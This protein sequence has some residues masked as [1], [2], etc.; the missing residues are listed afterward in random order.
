MLCGLHGQDCDCLAAMQPS[1]AIF[2]VRMPATL[3]Q[4]CTIIVR[5][6]SLGLLWDAVAEP[7]DV[8]LSWQ[9]VSPSEALAAEYT[10]EP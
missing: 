7:Q 6:R 4:L 3:M 2:R 5:E 8:A 1:A 10:C 9:T